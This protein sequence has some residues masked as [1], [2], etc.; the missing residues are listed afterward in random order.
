[1]S[2][3]RLVLFLLI[4]L[5]LACQT[6]MPASSPMPSPS[7]DGNQTSRPTETPTALPEQ[8]PCCEVRLHPEE[9]LYVGDQISFEVIAPS[10]EP[11]LNQPLTVTLTTPPTRIGSATFQPFGFARRTQATLLWAWDTSALSAADY[12]LRFSIPTLRQE[13]VQTVTLLPRNALPPAQQTAQWETLTTPC[14][15]IHFI[16]NTAAQRD[17]EA[18]AETVQQTAQHLQA[19]IPI[20]PQERIGVALIPRL[21]GN[22]GFA[23]QE[24][25]VSYLDRN[26][27]A[28]DFATILRHEMVHVFDQL[29][30]SEDRPSLFVEGMAVFLSGGHY[31][32]EPLM[33]RAA[34]LLRLHKF[35]PLEELTEDFYAAQ[36]EIAYLEAGALVEYLSARWGWQTV[37]EAYLAMSLR[38]GETQAQ[39]IERALKSKLG[40]SFGELAEDFKA[41]LANMGENRLLTLDIQTLDKYYETLRAYQQQFDPSADYRTA[42]MLDAQAMRQRGIVADYLRH[43]SRPENIALELLLNEAGRARRSGEYAQAERLIEAVSSVLERVQAKHPNPFSGDRLAQDAWQVV[44]VLLAAGYEPQVWTLTH[45]QAQVLVSQ[46]TPILKQVILERQNDGWQIV[47]GT[48]AAGEDLIHWAE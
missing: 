26:Y 1:M 34:E 48:S 28:G 25:N 8:G 14:C 30:Q 44:Q 15:D 43:P 33:P 2:S 38:K 16:T 17:I 40:L 18:I 12:T 13:W 19:K 22:G 6:P 36:H 24:I 42:W 7:G 47:S 29:A 27:S 39:A 10:A 31:F 21:I 41:E 3:K 4:F 32:P 9:A 5:V 45:D 46:A 35:I 23:N 20:D 11:Y 37:W